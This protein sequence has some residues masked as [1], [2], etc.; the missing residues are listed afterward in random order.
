M[1]YLGQTV[2]VVRISYDGE[3]KLPT[4]GDSTPTATLWR[5]GSATAETVTPTTT[6]NTGEFKFTFVIPEGW[7]VGDILHLRAIHTIDGTDHPAVIWED[8]IVHVPSALTPQEV[9]EYSERA[10]TEFGFSVDVNGASLRTGVGLASANLDTQLSGIS[11]KTTNL[12]SSP[13]AVGSAMTLTTG[14]RS[15]LAVAIEAALINEGDGQQLIDAIL[16]V[17]N[18]NLDLPSLELAAIAGAVRAE[19]ATELARLDTN[20]G[21]RAAPGDEMDLVDSPNVTSVSAIQSGLSTFN[22]SEDEVNVGAVNGTSVSGPN[23]LKADISGVPADVWSHSEREITGAVTVETNNDK[24]GY[25]LTSG[26]RTAIATA[27]ESALI[28]EGD[29]QQLID[30]IIQVINSSLDVPALELAAIGNA[31]RTELATEL[32]RIDAA[33]SSRAASGSQMDLVN[34]P[35][36]TAVAAIQNGLSTFNPSSDTVN[37]GAVGGAVVSGPNDLKADLSGVPEAVWDHETRVLSAFSFDVTVSAASVSAIRSDLATTA[38]LGSLQSHGDSNWATATGYSTFDPTEDT[39]TVGQNNDKAGYSLTSGERIAIATATEA[40]LINEGDGQHL[41]DAIVQVINS[42]LDIPTLELSAI[43]NAVRTELASELARIDIAVSSRAVPGSQMDLVNSPNA[44]AVTAIQSGLAMEDSRIE[45]T[46]NAGN[47]G[48]ITVDNP[49]DELAIDG[50]LNDCLMEITDVSTGNKQTRWIISHFLTS[51]DAG[52]NPD[53]PFGFT[54]VA[55]DTIVIYKQAR[56]TSHVMRWNN[57]S[58]SGLSSGRVQAHVGSMAANTVTASAVAADAVAEIQDGLLNASGVRDAVGLASANLDTQLGGIY[59]DTQRVDALIEDSDGDRFTAKSLESAPTEGSGGDDASSIYTH[60][61]TE[62]RENAFKTDVS[63]LSTFD[64]AEDT[65]TVGQNN[66]K[67]GYSL[68]SG[69]RVAIA[70]TTEAA[71]INEGDGQQLID[72]ILQV[73]NSNLDLPALELTAI[74]NAVRTELANELSRLDVAVSSRSTLTTANLESRTLPSAGY[75][76]FNPA[77]DTVDIGKVA[78]EAVTEIEDFHSP[79]TVDL[80]EVAKKNDLP[81]NFSSLGINAQGHL[82]RVSLVDTTT[83]NTD[84]RGTDGAA[85]PGQAM[86]LTAGE[87]SA[88]AVAI[89]AA[90]INEGDGQQLIDAILQVI[91][92]NLNLPALELTAIADAVR[93]ELSVELTRIDTAISTRAATGSKMDLVDSPN[94]L[95]LSEIKSGLATSSG[96]SSLATLSGA[97]L[98]EVQAVPEEVDTVLSDS[99]GAGPWGPG[100]INAGPSVVSITVSDADSALVSGARVRISEVG[101]SQKFVGTTD[102]EGKFSVSIDDGDYLVSITKPLFLF[103]PAELTVSGDTTVAYEME[104]VAFEGPDSPELCLV[105]SRCVSDTGVAQS[106]VRVILQLVKAPEGSVGIAASTAQ[107][108]V[109]SGAGGVVQFSAIRGGRYKVWRDGQPEKARLTVTLPSDEDVVQLNS[110]I[111]P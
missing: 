2:P 108:E 53:V 93:S 3:T 10:L 44:A 20:V 69:E 104:P 24:T 30:A 70:T 87:R 37:V 71:L 83:S 76:T 85:Q 52:F 90:L 55:G 72:A 31:V 97:I 38:G 106:G 94:S 35:N 27:T 40:A 47:T 19:L 62:G 33:V 66:D 14:E 5:N 39:V 32:A 100:V 15:T 103:V 81:E 45:A 42:N 48:W 36:S 78:G 61:T 65:V 59:T 109:V 98:T 34:S 102:S 105:V 12:P 95:A 51:G 29:G 110:F 41:I 111:G 91:N 89:E 18:S 60:F 25:S 82:S 8:E 7:N 88:L 16:Q 58:P 86:S 1:A 107:Q 6:A 64:P 22:A 57:G 79:L 84:M 43:A 23:D 96:V 63:D 21:S 49:T 46:L 75:S 73:I 50:Y 74:A 28:N 26:E 92:S 56:M 9:W 80:S 99:H 101:G 67:T 17:I 11:N 77:E 4:N 13:A 68:T 54:P